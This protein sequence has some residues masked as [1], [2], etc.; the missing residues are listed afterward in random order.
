LT[1]RNLGVLVPLG[2]AAA[3]AA[4]AL[5]GEPMDPNP[6]DIKLGKAGG[7]RYAKDPAPFDPG[8]SNA[9]QA[10]S[11]CGADAWQIAGGGATLG[12]PIADREFG[13]TRPANAP[14]L[15]T[16][17]AWD[18]SGIGT[19]GEQ[20]ATY[21]VC[22]REGSFHYFTESV[23]SG[24]ES[25]R[26]GTVGCG[27][28]QRWHV[29]SGGAIIATSHSHLISSFPF[30]SP[31]SDDDE[32]PD[33]GWTVFVDDSIGGGGGMSVYVVC[34]KGQG[35]GYESR[36]RNVDADSGGAITAGCPNARHVVGGGWLASP[37]KTSVRGAGTNPVD[38][39]DAGTVPDDGW[40]SAVFNSSGSSKGLTSFAICLG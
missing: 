13:V 1:W 36:K 20:L 31:V 32:R 6:G 22:R 40:R 5:A 8:N 38:D 15:T 25:L 7:L 17:D 12:G 33:D 27:P 39:G 3:L 16:K 18:A 11:G 14:L 28:D 34:M 37:S 26:M 10:Y 21:S 4:S 23:K 19:E 24:S 2:A 29:V 30:D 35:I 9:A